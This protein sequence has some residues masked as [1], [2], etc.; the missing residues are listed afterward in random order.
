M[1]IVGTRDEAN[2]PEIGRAVGARPDP[3]GKRIDLI[4]SEWQWPATTANIRASGRAAVTFSRPSDYRTYQIKGPADVHPAGQEDIACAERYCK[5]AA[6]L[7][8]E[9]G[10]DEHLAAHWLTRRDAA[11][12]RLRAEQVFEQTPGPRAGRPIA[13][14]A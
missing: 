7:L 10:L 3:S 4:V 9:L 13:G 2:R 12:I 5:A 6:S 14:S 1:I 11:L 8:A